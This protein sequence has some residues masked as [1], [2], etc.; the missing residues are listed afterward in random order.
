MRLAHEQVACSCNAFY[1]I[2]FVQNVDGVKGNF[3]IVA[4]AS[5]GGLVHYNREDDSFVQGGFD[6]PWSSPTPFASGDVNGVSLIQS[7]FTT[8]GKHHLEAAYVI[9]DKL[10]DGGGYAWSSPAL[11]ASGVRGTP[12]FIQ[13]K[14]GTVGNFEVVVPLAAGGIAHYFRD[15]D[16]GA[17]WVKSRTF[18][19]GIYDSVAMIRPAITSSIG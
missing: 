7:S 11:I 12:A 8:N 6:L 5:A 16:S 2:G 3:E 13:S 15:N 4:P 19:S 17:D 14:V 1:S 18:G 9:A 10:Y